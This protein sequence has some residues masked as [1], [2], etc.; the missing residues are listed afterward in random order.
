M[1]FDINID[2]DSILHS[3]YLINQNI[4]QTGD[5]QNIQIEIESSTPDNRN[6]YQE[7]YESIV[8]YEY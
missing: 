5:W 6:T 1:S 8:Y 7:Y 3:S 2:F 4:K